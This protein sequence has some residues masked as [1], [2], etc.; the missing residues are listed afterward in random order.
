MLVKTDDSALP[1]RQMDDFDQKLSSNDSF[2]EHRRT[3]ASRQRVRLSGFR[4]VV[5]SSNPVIG[6][7]GHKRSLV[8]DRYKAADMAD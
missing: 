3:T 8:S 2:G 5:E 6:A 1:L 7:L 4:F